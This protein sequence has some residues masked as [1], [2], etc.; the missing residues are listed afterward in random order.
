MFAAS[1]LMIINKID[2]LPYL[3]FDVEA[4]IANAN[5]QIT[6]IQLSATSGEGMDAWLAW[7]ETNVCA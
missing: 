2:L 5:P 3:H 1:S 6:V 7:L 4:C